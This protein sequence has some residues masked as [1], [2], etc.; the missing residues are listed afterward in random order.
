M[1]RI[2]S[3]VLTGGPNVKAAGGVLIG[4]ANPETSAY[5]TD[6]AGEL[7]TGLAAKPAG[8]ISEDG[9]SKTVDRSTEKIKDWNGDTVHIVQ[10][11]HAVTLKL[12]YLEA[13]NAEVLKSIAGEN[14][15]IVRDGGKK[16][17]IRDTAD[18]LPHRSL[19]F[20]IKGSTD[21]KIRLFAP[22]A[23]ATE[24][25]DVSYVRSDVIK[26]EVTYECFPDANDAKLYQFIDRKKV[27]GEVEDTDEDAGTED[28]SSTG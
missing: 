17:E 8:F 11:D 5:P 23:Q 13:A 7:N 21:S 3:N 2:R 15:V 28:V 16:I 14:N 20:E 18:E 10:S 22:D 6:A 12:T 19:V 1:A 27:E 26:Y 24:V 25:G 9:V 4:R